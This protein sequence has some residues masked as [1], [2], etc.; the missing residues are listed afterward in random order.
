MTISNGPVRRMLGGSRN[1][2]RE[3]RLKARPRGPLRAARR[4]DV[5]DQDF[6]PS[7]G[8]N[9][10]NFV[11][12][13]PTGHT[14]MPAHLGGSS[15]VDRARRSQRRGRRFDPG[16][17]HHLLLITKFECRAARRTAASSR[18]APAELARGTG[19]ESSARLLEAQIA[20]V[21][22][23][24][25]RPLLPAVASA[26]G[27]EACPACAGVPC[28]WTEGAISRELSGR[29]QTAIQAPATGSPP[30]AG[31]IYF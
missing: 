14:D 7:Q 20:W 16:L 29:W 23:G 26:G 27:V 25:I 2:A 19:S 5:S 24:G 18:S 21:T 15:S 28:R 13:P 11:L 8:R 31:W 12:L 10:E 4:P 17:L 6:A 9:G 3:D 1:L 30:A 22:L